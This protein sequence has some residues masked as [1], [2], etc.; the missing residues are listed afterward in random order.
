MNVKT[1]KYPKNIMPFF[2][3]KTGGLFLLVF[4]FSTLIPSYAQDL[5]FTQFYNAPFITNPALTGVFAGDLRINTNYRSQWTSVPVSYQTGSIAVDKKF[6]NDCQDASGFFSGG[7]AVNFDHAADSE[8][9]LVQVNTSGSYTKQLGDHWF[10]TT[11]I[12]LGGNYR[13]FSNERLIVDENY[14]E[15]PN[16]TPPSQLPIEDPLIRRGNGADP[17]RNNAFFDVST[18]INFR[19]QALEPR[20]LINDWSRRSKVDFGIGIFHLNQPDQRFFEDTNLASD[21]PM[22]FTPYLFGVYQ[23]GSSPYDLVGGFRAEFQGPYRQMLG[24][25]GAKLHLDTRGGE[26]LA[27]QIGFNYRFNPELSDA[28]APAVELHLKRIQVGFTYDVNTSE[29]N[30]ATLS[31]AGPEFSVQYRIFEIPYVAPGCRLL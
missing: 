4:W 1:N 29:F 5:H 27:L 14:R 3:K 20:Q 25:M 28:F 10:A 19:Y 7:L 18:G 31:R 12:Q 30:D 11:G 26:H 6:I 16:G 21:L 2:P 9:Q 22:R 15:N 13:R 8:L 24:A 23:L 17:A